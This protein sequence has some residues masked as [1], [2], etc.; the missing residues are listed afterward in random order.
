MYVYVCADVGCRS[1]VC[2]GVWRKCWSGVS[3]GMNC[4]PGGVHTQEG[5]H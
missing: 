4:E 5:L 1:S 2:V 3:A